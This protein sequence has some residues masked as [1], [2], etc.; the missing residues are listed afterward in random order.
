MIF[1]AVILRHFY[2]Y[3]EHVNDKTITVRGIFN[4]NR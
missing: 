1:D 4:D 2:L 3:I